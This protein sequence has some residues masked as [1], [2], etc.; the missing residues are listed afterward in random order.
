MANVR[1]L[2]PHRE[3]FLFVD[4]ILEIEENRI[5]TRRIM[6]SD[7]FFYEGHYPGKPIVVEV[8]TAKR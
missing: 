8:V 4:R 7:D 3:P 1:H 5:T 2:I 6:D